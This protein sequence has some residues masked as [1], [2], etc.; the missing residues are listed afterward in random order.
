LLI[1]KLSSNQLNL[2]IIW[3]YQKKI[4]ICIDFNRLW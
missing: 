3:I 1:F 2:L 4:E